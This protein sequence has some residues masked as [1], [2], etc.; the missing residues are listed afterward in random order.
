[1]ICSYI[2]T[3]GLHGNMYYY[4]VFAVGVLFL[5]FSAGSRKASGMVEIHTLQKKA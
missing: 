5:F 2:H 3:Q 4:G 1:M